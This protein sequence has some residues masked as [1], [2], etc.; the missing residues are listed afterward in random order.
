MVDAVGFV[1]AWLVR[2]GMCR[3]C[4]FGRSGLIGLCELMLARRGR[5]PA[6]GRWRRRG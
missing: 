6:L 4:W 1:V 3:Q 2:T 5:R